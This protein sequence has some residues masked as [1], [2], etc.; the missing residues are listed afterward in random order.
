[1]YCISGNVIEI[2]QRIR[3]ALM[4]LLLPYIHLMEEIKPKPSREEC[5]L[6]IYPGRGDLST[7]Y[8][9]GRLNH[10]PLHKSI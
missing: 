9:G 4:Q 1:M 5:L 10:H 6:S 3:D 7:V 2:L 8:I